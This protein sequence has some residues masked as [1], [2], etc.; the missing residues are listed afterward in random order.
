VQQLQQIT[1]LA[2]ILYFQLLHLQAV[3]ALQEL[4]D[5]EMVALAV[6]ALVRQTQVQEFR[7]KATMV[8]AQAEIPRVAAAVVALV[9]LALL[10]VLAQAVMVAQVFLITFQVHL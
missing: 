7:D 3:V 2:L 5:H 1:Q 4:L 6:V 9:V 8:E 10:V